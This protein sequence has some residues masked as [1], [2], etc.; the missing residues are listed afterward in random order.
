MDVALVTWSGLP[1]LDPDDRPIAAALS[2]RGLEV[3]A[4]AWDD[5]AFDWGRA[6]VA[7]LRSTWDYHLRLEEFL[8]WAGH[9]SNETTLLNPLEVVQWNVHKGYLAELLAK[10]LPVVPT[11]FVRAGT[12]A[13]LRAILEDRGWGEA[14]LKPAVSADS[15]ETTRVDRRSLAAG[16]SHLDRLSPARD[17]MV[18]PYLASVATSGERC[19]TIIEGEI[20]HAVRK[21]SL[22]LGGRHAGP[23]GVAVPIEPDEADAA[24]RI[25]AGAGAED[26]L[27]ARVDLMRDASGRPLLSEIELVEPTLF[28]REQPRALERLADAVAERVARAT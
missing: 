13:N 1:D 9:V 22:F 6:R 10:G 8:A 20:S 3:G 15:W 23:E 19:L 12:R 14:V 28:V 18:Q 16:Q 4:V 26:L 17:M 25:V 2:R 5:P 11:A 27:Y 24:R 21:N 7:W